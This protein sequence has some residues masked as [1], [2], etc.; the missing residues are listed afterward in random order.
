MSCSSAEMQLV[1]STVSADE[2]RIIIGRG[3]LVPLTGTIIPDQWT[4][5]NNDN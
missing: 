2:A 1:Y 3:C 4:P 5:G